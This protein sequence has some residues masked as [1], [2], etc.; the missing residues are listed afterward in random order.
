MVFVIVRQ[1]VDTTLDVINMIYGESMHVARDWMTKYV[2][3]EMESLSMCPALK[4][5]KYN[6]YYSKG[7]NTECSVYRKYKQ[8]HKGYMYNTSEWKS[9]HVFTISIIEYD[10]S[11]ICFQQSS[12]LWT[13]INIE[14]N[15]R[16][17]RQLDTNT[18]QNV[19]AAIQE[20]CHAKENWNTDEYVSLVSEILKEHKKELFNKVDKSIRRFSKKRDEFVR[21]KSE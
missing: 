2:Y 8:V 20:R 9:E 6:S 15:N 14:I 21:I 7:T 13:K 4:N 11:N 10:G 16:V 18:L 12:T 5:T 3:N 19:F 17:L 1:N